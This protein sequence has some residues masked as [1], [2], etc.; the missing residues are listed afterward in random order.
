MKKTGRKSRNVV[1]RSPAENRAA[2]HVSKG[3]GEIK[4]Q[5][6]TLKKYVTKKVRE[7]AASAKGSKKDIS[8]R[9]KAVQALKSARGPRKLKGKK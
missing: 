4:K 9:K 7:A 6:R 1:V 5:N 2:Q 8:S 3:L